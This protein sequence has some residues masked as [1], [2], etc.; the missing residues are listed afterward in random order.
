M[1]SQYNNKTILMV[2]DDPDD[3]FLVRD[4]FWQSGFQGKL[5]LVSDGQELMEYLCRCGKLRRLHKSPL[6]SL[7]LLDLHMPGKDGREALLEI[8]NDPDFR[9]IPI[10]IFTSSREEE[11]VSYCYELGANSYVNKPASFDALVAL[12]GKLGEYWI[13]TAKLPMCLGR[14]CFE[15]SLSPPSLSSTP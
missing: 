12:I 7:I 14:E 15:L 1:N 3:F 10:V 5:H 4:A 6:P 11:D 13:G 2:D 9:R 8:K